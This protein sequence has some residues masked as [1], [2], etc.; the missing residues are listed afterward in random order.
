MTVLTPPS[1]QLK[2]RVLARLAQKVRN[3]Q[4]P[5]DREPVLARRLLEQGESREGLAVDVL[6]LE[7]RDHLLGERLKAVSRDLG[8]IGLPPLDT[9]GHKD[10]TLSPLRAPSDPG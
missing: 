10:D 5:L 4:S 7:Q 2:I 8:G 9:S 3:L 1:T 6:R